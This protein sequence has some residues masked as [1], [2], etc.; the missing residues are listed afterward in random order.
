MRILITERFLPEAELQLKHLGYEVRRAKNYASPTQEEIA[1]AEIAIIR[2]KTQINTQFLEQAK[3]LR[4]VITLTSGFDHIDAKACEKKDVKWTCTPYANR[5]SAGEFTIALALQSLRHLKKIDLSSGKM[6]LDRGTLIGTE[7]YQKTWGIMG[8]GRVGSYVAK[9]AKGFGANILAYDPYIENR[10]FKDHQAERV[11]LSELFKCSDIVSIHVPKTEE[12]HHIIT[13]DL[14]KD[15]GTEGLFI[16][17]ARK[18]V[19]ST[20]ALLKALK[21]KCIGMVAL[22][23]FDISEM[24]K[25]QITNF[26]NVFLSPHLGAASKEALER[27]SYEAIELIKKMNI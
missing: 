1:Y 26:P 7:I 18:H 8:L 27:A 22:D 4:F 13:F 20:D 16:N 11:S 2:S 17:M 5:I 15:L 21:E 19:L 12:T 6:P 25:A 14:L 24:V 10:V 3:N 23:V 9:L